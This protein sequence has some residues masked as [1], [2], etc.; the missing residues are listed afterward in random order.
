M[1]FSSTYPNTALNTQNWHITK[2]V[3]KR[4]VRMRRK[5]RLYRSSQW[6]P[7]QIPNAQI[8]VVII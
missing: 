7:L 5:F 4:D 2:S 1:K 3:L 6:A 8:E